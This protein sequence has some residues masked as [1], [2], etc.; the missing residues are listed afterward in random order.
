MKKVIFLVI[1]LLVCMSLFAA[2]A[3]ETQTANPS[4]DNVSNA[5]VSEAS[6]ASDET[7]ENSN[8]SDETDDVS[9]AST[10]D[11][12]EE[13]SA[14][15]EDPENTEPVLLDVRIEEGDKKSVY[16]KEYDN[17]NILEETIVYED[18]EKKIR[19][20]ETLEKSGEVLSHT[21]YVNGEINKRTFF[22][23][24]KTLYYTETF[25]VSQ[26]E[27]IHFGTTGTN[28][29]DSSDRLLKSHYGKSE[30]YYPENGEIYYLCYDDP[31][32]PWN[33][34]LYS[35]FTK[36]YEPQTLVAEYL[37][38][39]TG[40]YLSVE[41]SGEGYTEQQAEEIIK[42]VDEY[43]REIYEISDQWNAYVHASDKD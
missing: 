25:E 17:G 20:S 35:G 39:E 3:E 43:R 27:S 4:D 30:V 16:Y 31:S 29:Y 24:G 36:F 32:D 26:E 6:V 37:A 19:K 18:D 33:M 38:D 34:W 13:S 14:V 41:A 7:S 12:G 10:S 22:I 5:E 15:V 42:Q 40:W 9:D 28:Y 21:E 2:C 1:S 23:D 8:A 11:G